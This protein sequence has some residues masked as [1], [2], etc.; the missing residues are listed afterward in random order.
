MSVEITTK[1]TFQVRC[2][3]CDEP[4]TARMGGDYAWSTD[5]IVVD[6]CKECLKEAAEDARINATGEQQ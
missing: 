6:P 3:V 4:L 5:V 2:G 1:E